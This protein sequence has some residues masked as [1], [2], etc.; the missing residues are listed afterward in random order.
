[1]KAQKAQKVQKCNGAMVL[2][3]HAA[4]QGSLSQ[5]H[6]EKLDR[7][8][9]CCFS[10][11]VNEHLKRCTVMCGNSSGLQVTAQER[12]RNATTISMLYCAEVH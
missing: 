2:F 4:G 1:M 10:S 6:G 9:L 8:L 5:K 12:Q 3:E 11:C 7:K